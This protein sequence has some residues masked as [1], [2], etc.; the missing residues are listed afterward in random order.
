[1]ILKKCLNP[2]IVIKRVKTLKIDTHHTQGSMPKLRQPFRVVFRT[3]TKGVSR[4][5]VSGTKLEVFT[6][7]RLIL[8]HIFTQAKR[9][10]ISFLWRSCGKSLT[11]T[12][13]SWRA[14]VSQRA[15]HCFTRRTAREPCWAGSAALIR[16]TGCCRGNFWWAN[17][18]AC[19]S[20]RSPSTPTANAST[21]T[22]GTAWCACST[23]SPASFCRTTSAPSLTS[24]FFIGAAREKL[25]G[26]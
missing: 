13:V 19:R 18:A 2:K 23:S 14:C 6:S 25:K 21:F 11:A 9:N 26:F 3:I 15:A 12:R 22:P 20:T 8:V 1:M 16:T 4:Q 24:Q 5:V 17:C 7:P 10:Q